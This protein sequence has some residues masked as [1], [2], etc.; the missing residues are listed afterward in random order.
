MQRLAG[1]APA[2][3]P[4]PKNGQDETP[5]RGGRLVVRG[6][7]RLRGEISV[8]GAK[9]AALPMMTAALLTREPVTLEGI[10]DI[11]DVHT[12]AA[13]LRSLG[14]T[15]E[16]EPAAHRMTIVADTLTSAALPTALAQSVRTSFLC[17][18]PLLARTG[19]AA[20]S[21]PGGCNIGE[22]P[23]NVDVRGLAA[24]GA[25]IVQQDGAYVAQTRGLQSAVIYL[26]YPSVTGTENLMMAACLAE[27]TT[28]IKHAACEPEVVA[29]AEHLTR[30]G[31]MIHGAGTPKI[32]VLGRESL[33]SAR[34]QVIP[35]RL[36]AGMFALAAAITGGDVGIRDVIPEHLDAVTYKLR[37]CG[38]EVLEYEDRL[39][40][41]WRRPLQATE[42][43]AIH[44]PGF[45]TDMQAPFAV[46]MT[47][48]QGTSVIHERV[49]ENRL[50]YAAEVAKLGARIDV[51]SQ[52]TAHVH[53]PV[54]LLGTTVAALDLRC[55]IALV[56][57]GLAAEG[58]TIVEEAG[59]IRR[60]YE[61][62]P[63][64]LVSLGAEL[65]AVV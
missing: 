40:V 22:R 45:P 29:L 56:L 20:L 46:L 23:V 31:A 61:Q 47:Q 50:L 12:Q 57:A 8:R 24:M 54:R 49:F 7:R 21:R 18:G 62:L 5:S 55:G 28:V 41:R 17:L 30:M 15:V 32:E 42:I 33:Y 53:G 63:E 25:E 65:E 43:Q 58:T 10:P 16:W 60:G 13:L 3:A 39:E 37:E 64:R 14:A 51:E 38:V 27:G 9:N 4:A 2:P 6:R 36:E 35:D 19:T 44:Y 26:D 59:H 34:S 11:E 1:A 52:V 48:A